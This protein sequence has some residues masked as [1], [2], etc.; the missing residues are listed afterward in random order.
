MLSLDAGVF[1][2]LDHYCN[3]QWVILVS[4]VL[5]CVASVF[6]F[7]SVHVMFIINY[8]ISISDRQK[9]KGKRCTDTAQIFFYF[10]ELW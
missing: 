5:L 4:S 6:C 7:F 2:L 8:F 10:R 3:A 9:I 1:H